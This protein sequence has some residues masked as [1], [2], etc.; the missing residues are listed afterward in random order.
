MQDLNLQSLEKI[1]AGDVTWRDVAVAGGGL[2]GGTFGGALGAAG[3]GLAG[4]ALYDALTKK[5]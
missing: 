5:H 3:G 4:G 1:N 2:L